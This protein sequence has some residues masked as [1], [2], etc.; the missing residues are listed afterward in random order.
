M[1]DGCELCIMV[2]IVGNGIGDPSKIQD[3]T[4]WIL[5]CVNALGRGMNQSVP[6]QL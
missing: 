1:S 4:D 3:K 2:I 6:P 5:L